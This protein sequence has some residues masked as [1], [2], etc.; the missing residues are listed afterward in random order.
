M[1]P[2]RLLNI[3]PE[4]ARLVSDPRAFEAAH[5]ASFGGEA[6]TIKSVVSVNESFRSRN[7]APP[8]WGGYLAIDPLKKRV[9]GTCAFKGSPIDGVVEIAFFTF[10]PYGG[11]GYATAMLNGLI[12]ICRPTPAVRKLI[13]HTMPEENAVTAIL[14][15]NGFS[16]IGDKVDPE[17]G[18]VW[19]WERWK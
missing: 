8:E 16:K 19:L 14:R 11:K 4:V 5:G 3:T 9:V 6:E 7:G 18:P 17:D 1:P 15:K 13:A 2:L 10:E 12:D